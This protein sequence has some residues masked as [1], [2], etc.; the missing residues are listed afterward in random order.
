M[1][2]LLRIG[3]CS[4]LAGLA[5]AQFS[6]D[7]TYIFSELAPSHLESD[8]FNGNGSLVAAGRGLFTAKTDGTYEVE[9]D[10]VGV[11]ST[12]APLLQESDEGG[13][14]YTSCEGRIDLDPSGDS[15]YLY[16]SADRELIVG[17]AES[18]ISFDPGPLMIVATRTSSGLSTAD[19][20]GSYHIGRLAL[21]NSGSEH[22]G[23]VW[24]GT[25]TFDGAGGV[26]GSYDRKVVGPTGATSFTASVP[27]SG[28]YSVASNGALVLGGNEGGFAPT[29][30]LFHTIDTTGTELAMLVGVPVA[31]SAT[32]ATLARDWGYAEL[33][34]ETDD[35][36]DF[37]SIFGL[38]I[39]D[40]ASTDCGVTPVAALDIYLTE[41]CSDPFFGGFVDDFDEA[42]IPYSVASDGEILD[43]GLVGAVNQAGSAGFVTGALD[44][45]E[46]DGELSLIVFVG[47]EG[48]TPSNEVMRNAAI[49]NP[50]VFMPGEGGRPVV[51]GLWAPTVDHTTF[52]PGAIGDFMLISAAPLELDFGSKGFLLCSP[53]FAATL[54]DIPYSPEFEVPIPDNCIF[55]GLTLCAQVGA[56]INTN[57]FRL[58]NAIDFT[59]GTY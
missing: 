50:N 48:Q 20:S 45:P 3:A 40:D 30:G 21:D 44:D 36:D 54:F 23:E 27:F 10:L 57:D 6:T 29:S 51:G 28:T 47:V 46:V 31:S 37:C 49:P 32:D 34:T 2:T 16:V 33:F 4:A 13:G 17:G 41:V 11:C 15:A 8:C 7:T 43:L 12:G 35:G 55:V 22:A 58:T 56:A 59:I 19:L 5:G 26:T 53:P 38:L 42:C 9:S 25:F 18:S 1:K 39:G 14:T 24:F 52:E